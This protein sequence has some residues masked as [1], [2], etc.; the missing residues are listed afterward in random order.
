M[1]PGL[2]YIFENEEFDFVLFLWM[3]MGI[4]HEEIKIL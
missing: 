4:V 3:V 1:L 2:K